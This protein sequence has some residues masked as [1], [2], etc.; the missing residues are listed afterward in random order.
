MRE[1]GSKNDGVGD[2]PLPAGPWAERG[3]HAVS[4][5][6]DPWPRG[7]RLV[8]ASTAVLSVLLVAVLLIYEPREPGG[9]GAAPPASTHMLPGG[10]DEFSMPATVEPTMPPPPSPTP[11]MPGPPLPAGART[12]R[13]APTTPQT[14]Y[15]A[16][17]G[18][19]CPQ[20]AV[21]GFFYRG[22]Y[23]EW[24]TRPTGGWTGDGCAG[25]V[26]SVP[27]SGDRNIDDPDNVVVWWFRVPAGA[28]CAIA[29]YV[30][31]TGY[32]L[33]AAGAP[34]TYLVYATTDAT[35]K[36]IAQFNVDQVHNQ[37]R[38]VDVGTFRAGGDQLSV[39]LAT[40]GIDF[41]PGRDGAHLGV[42]ALRA[43]C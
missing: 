4:S 17:A 37:G 2:L 6:S 14:H 18:E 13:P 23:R 40:R 15:V 42:S 36:Q 3:R 9:S 21:S 7:R 31:G 38:W 22:W 16:V 1:P 43:R 5:L 33:D 26:I 35:G 27:M 20:T 10:V 12:T 8:L 39:R 28:G 25:R 29:V 32:V 34:A 41:G 30:P 19:S 11:T 24:Y